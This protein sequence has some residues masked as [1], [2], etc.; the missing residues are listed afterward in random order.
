[1]QK[2]M[3]PISA[4]DTLKSLVG[5]V[6]I[7]VMRIKAPR[8]FTFMIALAALGG[9]VSSD[10]YPPRNTVYWV[11]PETGSYWIPEGV[12]PAT[13]LQA[14]SDCGARVSGSIANHGIV[15]P[16]ISTHVFHF[17]GENNSQVKRCTIEK[18]NAI[19]Q[20]SARL[21]ERGRM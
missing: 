20:L 17:A 3:E 10:A 15:P 5:F 2:M 11:Q 8:A 16:G 7:R 1:M 13:I 9:C 18:L 6:I 12:E 4:T 14:A 21:R 19:P